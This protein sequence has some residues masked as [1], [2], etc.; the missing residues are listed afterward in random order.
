MAHATGTRLASAACFII[1][2]ITIIGIPI[3][4]PI[5]YLLNQKAAEKESEREAEFEAATG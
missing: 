4:W 3:L 2:G 1:G 5:G